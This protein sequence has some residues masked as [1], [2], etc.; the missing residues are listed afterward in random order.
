M[1]FHLVASLFSWPQVAP[2]II[3]ATRM[4]TLPKINDHS[5]INGSGKNDK[6]AASA[7][8]SSLVFIVLPFLL[9]SIPFAATVISCKHAPC[10][11]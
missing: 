9:F 5:K 1:G 7:N 2:Q 11:A 3:V 6:N 4:Y 8:L 10:C